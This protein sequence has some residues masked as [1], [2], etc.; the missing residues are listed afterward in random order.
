MSNVHNILDEMAL[1]CA[2]CG[3]V[4]FSLLKSLCIECSSCGNVIENAKWSSNED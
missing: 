4:K 2:Y 1:S 3:C